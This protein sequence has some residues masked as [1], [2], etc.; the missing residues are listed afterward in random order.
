LH[1]GNR[2][3]LSDNK[4]SL[5]GQIAYLFRLNMKKR[6]SSEYQNRT[7]ECFARAF[8]QYYAIKNKI[9]IENPKGNYCYNEVFESI[10]SPLIEEFINLITNKIKQQSINKL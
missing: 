3:Y 5:P 7:K 4:K 8:E 6:Q 9:D 10:I 1:I 2:Y